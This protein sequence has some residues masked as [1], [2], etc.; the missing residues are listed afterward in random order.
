M[1]LLVLAAGASAQAAEFT[2]DATLTFCALTAKVH[3]TCTDRVRDGH[4]IVALDVDCKLTRDIAGGG[5]YAMAETRRRVDAADESL[6]V[7]QFDAP[8]RFKARY[9][10]VNR[11]LYLQGAIFGPSVIR[12]PPQPEDQACANRAPSTPGVDQ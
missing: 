4:N 7:T 11:G 8:H 2:H 5:S 12:F 6:E 3:A 1:A 9:C 10:A